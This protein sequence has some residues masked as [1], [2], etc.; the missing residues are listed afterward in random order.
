MVLPAVREP[1]DPASLL[2]AGLVVKRLG[3]VF[4]SI[5]NK[6]DKRL[7]AYLDLTIIASAYT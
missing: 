3:R 5:R 7:T 2:S 1:G 4:P 6:P